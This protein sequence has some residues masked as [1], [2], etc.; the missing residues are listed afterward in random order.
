[1]DGPGRLGE[2]VH[3]RG[4]AVPFMLIGV[5]GAAG[6][7]PRTPEAVADR[8]VDSYFV[9]M[10]QGRALPLAAGL[11]RDMLE[12]ELREVAS[13]RRQMGFMPADARPQVYYQ[14]VSARQ[15]GAQKIFAYDLT[16][17]HERDV[18]HKS[19]QI[20]VAQREGAWKVIF[21][22]VSDGEAPRR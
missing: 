17:K 11:A 8:F 21:Y 14:R 1:M 16:L 20:A 5:W 7:A 6:C 13:I 10:D 22:R 9:E 19:S 3:L 4:A 2:R 12:R 18:M 15:E